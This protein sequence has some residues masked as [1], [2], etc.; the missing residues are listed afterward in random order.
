M[1]NGSASGLTQPFYGFPSTPPLF[2][3][4]AGHST[5]GWENL[6]YATSMLRESDVLLQKLAS[7][8]LILRKCVSMNNE[9]IVSAVNVVLNVIE[10]MERM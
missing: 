10:M 2:H 9:K 1:Q 7:N 4:F 3:P 8:I 6:H 5:L